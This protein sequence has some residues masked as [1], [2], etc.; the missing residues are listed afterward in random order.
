MGDEYASLN[1][2]EMEKGNPLPDDFN[3]TIT[4]ASFIMYDYDGKFQ[5]A[6]P[7]IKVVFESEKYEEPV[8]S[9]Y[10][11]GNPG[12]WY[13]SEDGTKLKRTGDEEKIRLNSNAGLFMSSIVNSGFP[14]TKLTKDI[15]SI[16][17]LQGHAKRQLATNRGEGFKK[18]TAKDGSE[19]EPT[20]LLITEITV[21]PGEKAA[22]KGKGKGS[23][24]AAAV[25]ETLKS[26]AADLLVQ[27]LTETEGNSI[28]KAQIVSTVFNHDSVKKLG[29]QKRNTISR[30]VGEEDFLREGG[31]WTFKDGIV[32]L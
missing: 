12:D 16:V 2:D 7:A 15:S 5:Q 23:S 4:E 14:K 9:Y 19:I 11:A 8:P 3:F 20:I 18:R 27:I 13:P 21:M 26:E 6:V 17:G 28:P 30:L 10:K 31:P 32:S 29:A 25:D 1:P 22:G 24:A